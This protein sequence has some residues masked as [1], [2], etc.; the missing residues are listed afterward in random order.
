M[1]HLDNNS[2]IDVMPAIKQTSSRLAK[3]FTEGD[4]QT[5]P[6]YPGA[7][8]F[9]IVQSELLNVLKDAGITPAKAELNQLS[10]SIKAMIDKNKT[11]IGDASLTTKGIVKLSSAIDSAS[12]AEA[13]TSLAVKKTYDYVSNVK[14]TAELA[15]NIA[16]AAV[17]KGEEFH[18]YGY[19]GDK[20]INNLGASAQGVYFQNSYSEA[21]PERGYPI[22][23][24]G[25][26]MV[27][28][29]E[30]DGNKGCAQIYTLYKSGRQF[31][32]N[33]R[34]SETSGFWEPWVEQITTANINEYLPVGIP[35]PYPR[36]TPP[37][38]WLRCNGWQFDKNK[39]PKLA[40]AYPSGFL[41]ELRGEFIRGWD[42]GRGVDAGRNI[43]SWQDSAFQ[44][45]TGQFIG[46]SIH[47][48]NGAPE[49]TSTGVF[50]LERTLNANMTVNSTGWQ[51][52]AIYSFDTSR[53]N[54]TASE[55]RTR[56]VAFLYIVKAE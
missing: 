43:L 11:V 40:E 35:Q 13:A 21:Y 51:D 28:R 19:L 20:I 55:T 1:F 50:K 27:L 48:S 30:G 37:A 31:I 32:R 42:D 4:N 15:R 49:L 16:V 10:R 14:N 7:D 25:A 56:S 33:Y 18:Y 52:R 23:E 46:A 44:N 17:K 2:G 53:T 29:T 6:S 3:W 36:A 34:G 45:I 39:Y 9:N 26:L 12:E 8:W 47:T 41:P 38:G 24:A 54:L 5:P 22:R